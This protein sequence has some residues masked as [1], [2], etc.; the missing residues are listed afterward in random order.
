MRAGCKTRK[1]QKYEVLFVVLRLNVILIIQIDTRKFA[2]G[3][4]R[5][6]VKVASLVIHVTRSYLSRGDT[7]ETRKNKRSKFAENSASWKMQCE[8][9]SQFAAVLI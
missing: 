7:I 5:R 6:F 4:A 9:L 3:S 8:G 1:V 2:S